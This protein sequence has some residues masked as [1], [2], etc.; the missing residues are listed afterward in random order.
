MREKLKII[1]T[2]E[3]VNGPSYI[4]HKQNLS[5]INFD[6]LGVDV[7]LDISDEPQN[8][9]YEKYD[10]ALFMG[11]DEA[12]SVAKKKNDSILIGII[13]PRSAF[14]NS[15]R[16]IDFVV[17]NGIEAQ[18]YFSQF[19]QNI[20]IYYISP[21]VKPIKKI[22]TYKKNKIILGYH[23]NKIHLNS[24]FPRITDAI[25]LLASDYDVELWAMYN[26]NILGKWK[27]PEKKDFLFKVKHIQY[28]EE[29]YSKYIAY[30]DIGIVPQIIP[31]MK[32]NF[33]KYI[34]G[35]LLKKNN[36]SKHDYF[37]RFKED[38]NPGRHMVFAQYGI[39]V[40]SDMTPSACNLI[41]NGV[42]GY[43]AHHSMSWYNYMKILTNDQKLREA[44]G[45][46]FKEKY[47]TIATAKIQ[48]KNLLNFIINLKNRHFS[49]L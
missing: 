23:G 21:I 44:M 43:L 30:T 7:L 29:N 28:S 35:N 3:N 41:N 27:I 49:K 4:L 37:F 45:L 39:P 15:F 38:T 16:Y 6:T 47:E 1:F 18:D 22:S 2:S 42:N 33:L 34:S 14:K 32:N 10:V 13:D 8:V 17:A 11:Y 46:K 5:Q 48:N 19:I 36:E 40:I 24:M 12:S 25:N 9:K 26:I 20:F 31:F